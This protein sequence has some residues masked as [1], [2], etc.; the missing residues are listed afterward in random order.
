VIP[1]ES[2]EIKDYYTYLAIFSA[3]DAS[4]THAT[5]GYLKDWNTV[6]LHSIVKTILDKRK[7]ALKST[8]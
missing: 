5:F 7:A 1:W 2:A 3:T 6:V 8:V 4:K